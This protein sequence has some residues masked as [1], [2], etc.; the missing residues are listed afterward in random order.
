MK[1]TSKIFKKQYLSS[2]I[3]GFFFFFLPTL[4]SYLKSLRKNESFS[5]IFKLFWTYKI[6]LWIILLVSFILTLLAIFIGQF[7]KKKKD[8]FKY[9][10]SSLALDTKL[11]NKIS[12]QLLPQDQ[13][14]YWL[15]T[16]HFN[17]SF[18][19]KYLD[20]LYT[21]KDESLSSDFEFLNPKLEVIKNELF[22]VIINFN[23]AIGT[24]TFSTGP[25][26]QS[27]PTEWRYERSKRYTE[28]VCEM[29]ELAN[30]VCSN[31]DLL[32]KSCRRII[33]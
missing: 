27:I 17:S 2:I 31:Y 24:H 19:K 3:I 9:D 29:N 14:I 11:F 32:I 7:F 30:K 13:T 22:E 15:R 23:R 12:R 18:P 10:S 26:S 25:N 21:F 5:E 28:A 16:H 1:K 6:E 20:Q 8:K 4:I 33:K